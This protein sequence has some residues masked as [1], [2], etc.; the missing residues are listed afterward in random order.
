[1]NCY[2][3][4]DIL[5][6]ITGIS[7][8]FLAA[9][10]FFITIWQSWMTRKHNQNSVKPLLSFEIHYMRTNTGF[11]IYI[12]NNGLGPAIVIEFKINIDGK[13]IELLTNNPWYNVTTRL[14]FNYSFIQMGF[15]DKDTVIAAGGRSFLLTV[16]SNI[17]EDQEE[18]FKRIL[19]RIGMEIHYKS[20]YGIKDVVT[21]E[22]KS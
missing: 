18:H 11:G 4:T 13:D 14:D 15:Y 16:D 2:F 1:M 19:R 8:V 22:I 5:Q 6:L 17:N 12:N 3:N 7:A 21:L 9:A 20:I 10:A